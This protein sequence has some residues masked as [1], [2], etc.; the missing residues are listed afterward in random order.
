MGTSDGTDDDGHGED[1][2]ELALLFLPAIVSIDS[3]VSAS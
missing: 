1:D 3:D 2:D